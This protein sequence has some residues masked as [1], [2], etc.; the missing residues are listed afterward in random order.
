M[1]S[2]TPEY[3]DVLAALDE[4]ASDL[5]SA[6]RISAMR[7]ALVEDLRA[8]NQLAP[9]AGD[10]FFPIDEVDLMPEEKRQHSN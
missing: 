3:D 4:L 2:I 10:G 7:H 6:T 8:I 5:Q 1:S 9:W